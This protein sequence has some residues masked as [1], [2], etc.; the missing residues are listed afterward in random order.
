MAAPR[1]S[2]LIPNYNNGRESSLSGRDDL[3]G[4]LLQSL[5]DTLH[6]DPTSWEILAYDDGSTDDS[7]STLRRWS[8]RKRPDGRPFLEL[9]EAEHCGVLAR[10]ANVLSRRARGDILVR[11]DGDIVC[12]TPHW[13]S[14]LRDL[15]DRESADLGVVGPKQLATD[16]RTIIGCGD[17]VLHPCGYGHIGFG[18]PRGSIRHAM[19]V[20]HVMGCFYC[21]RRAVFERLGGYDERILRGQTV[22]FGLRARLDGW[23]CLAVPYIEFVHANALRRPRPTRADST[24]GIH[25]ALTVFRE[26]W[27]FDRLAPD[28]DA[29]WRRYAD[30]PLLWHRRWL[31]PSREP[32]PS[33]RLSVEDS[34][35]SRYVGDE[36]VRRQVDTKVRIVLDMV[37]QV[38]RPGLAI[39]VG[40]GHGVVEHLLATA[41]LPVVGFDHRQ[42]HVDLARACTR[43]HAY[44]AGG[45]RFEP[46]PH[47]TRI[48]L[49][50]GSA[51]LV[52]LLGRLERHP[53]P[54]GLLHEARRV[55]AKGRHLLVVS[56]RPPGPRPDPS[57]PEH[58]ATANP[59]HRYEWHQLLNQMVA[60]GWHL[61]VDPRRDD[62]SR[63]MVV[64]AQRP[65][66][67]A[68]K[69]AVD[70]PDARDADAA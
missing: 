46:M 5:A 57:D 59:E 20:D 64:A 34:T 19:E 7:L 31:G 62:P 26:K 35:W 44:P 23:R 58:I 33:P 51:D 36:A 52:M 25:E 16:Q 18:M 56:R 29:V 43:R 41:K 69:R 38:G 8:R 65:A 12:L 67:E 21:C 14:R 48:P 24:A 15:F 49:P 2:I 50:D 9:I 27:G 32:E 61:L 60:T 54:T 63:D 37:R 13:A 40:C 6:D 28:L 66:D 10:T 3:I 39:T 53:N 45:P 55:T 70:A 17:W 68:A 42:S 11:L 1:V 22:D 4:D 30:T 47:R